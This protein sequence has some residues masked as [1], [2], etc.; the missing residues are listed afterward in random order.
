MLDARPALGPRPTGVGTYTR[1]LIRHLP[2]ADP[3]TSYIAWYARRPLGRRPRFG[4]MPNLSER[5][6]PAPPAVL[7]V[8]S[9][10]LGVPKVEWFGEFD[11]I[12]ATN[13]LPPA[14]AHVD[15]AVLVVHDLAYKRFPES[16]PHVDERWSSRF[17]Q[18]LHRC[19][20]VV[21]PSASARDDLLELC[22][23]DPV[24][25]RVVHHGVDAEAFVPPPEAT[26][27]AVLERL[28]IGGPY[29]LF[30]GGIET[31]KNLEALVEAFAKLEGRPWL[32]IAGPPVP[33]DPAG[34][35]RLDATIEGLPD[36]VASHV[37]RTGFVTD[38][39]RNA[40]LAG[41]TT[42][43]YPSRYEG[44]GFP[45]LE[46]FAAGLP[47]MTSNVS[48]LPEVAGDAALLVD[49]NDVDAIAGG[50]AELFGDEDLRQDLRAAG[51]AR[52]AGF[53]W[54]ATARETARVLHGAAAADP[55]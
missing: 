55:R 21:V 3:D 29:A 19:A 33:W 31:R 6:L 44:F 24:R 26:V 40:L 10:R 53:T 17:T 49:P 16:A 50:L 38:S 34:A 54:E 4:R 36:R 1:H 27:R 9:W 8:L 32:V 52:V 51:Y 45:V 12:V 18:A 43:A 14:T 13:F 30:I 48:S 23:V 35:S 7:R 47:V 28:G 25:V 20:A 46:G 42:L 2:G 15:R 41:A 39:D 5:V 11:L 22:A 37:I